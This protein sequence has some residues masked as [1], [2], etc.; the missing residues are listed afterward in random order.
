MNISWWRISQNRAIK[1]VTLL[2]SILLVFIFLL[3][4]AAYYVAHSWQRSLNVV[5]EQNAEPT[6]LYMQILESASDVRFRVAAVVADRLPAVSSRKK[7]E[8]E[9]ARVEETWDKLTRIDF[10]STRK[11]EDLRIQ[12]S[13][14]FQIF[15]ASIRELLELYKRDDKDQLA[16]FI[17]EKWPAIT[18]NLLNPI[19]KLVEVHKLSIRESHDEAAQSAQRFLA[20]LSVVIVLSLLVG[21]Y[22]IFFLLGTE[23]S[24]REALQELAGQVDGLV[25]ASQTLEAGGTKLREATLAQASAVEESAASTQQIQVML[26]KSSHKTEQFVMVS[27]ALNSHVENGVSVLQRLES[28]MGEI[29]EMSNRMAH[30][31]SIIENIAD[32]T[33]VINDIV[34]KT[35][36]LSFN[37][38]IEAARAGQHGRGFAVVAEE[39]GSLAEISGRAAGDIEHLIHNSRRQVEEFVRETETR[40]GHGETVTRDLDRTYSEIAAQLNDF[41][42]GLGV[43]Q[44]AGV[45]QLR[46]LEHINT[47][48]QRIRLT[49]TESDES[50]VDLIGVAQQLTHDS[51]ALYQLSLGLRSLVDGAADLNEDQVVEDMPIPTI[52]IETR[53]GRRAA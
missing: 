41:R 49:T 22:S 13:Q 11:H 29:R 46:G 7:A 37:A 21:G 38:S 34:F 19:N 8:E 40:V 2:V 44:E 35:Q 39:I 48:M 23:K 51:D 16:D 26:E 24:I 25:S 10:A 20:G 4:G 45:E 31:M 1:K 27:N 52:S 43:V 32:K 47:S 6:Q 18:A 53:K 28:S 42:E 9:L 12:A 36:L 15:R 50:V 30:V 3:S 5:Y 17:D 33:K 14:G